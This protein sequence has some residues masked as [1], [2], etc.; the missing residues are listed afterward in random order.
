MDPLVDVWQQFACE[1]EEGA[2]QPMPSQ[3]LE[4]P[5]RSQD[6]ARANDMTPQWVCGL[7]ISALCLTVEYHALTRISSDTCASKEALYPVSAP[8]YVQHDKAG[9]VGRTPAA[10]LPN[11]T[12]LQRENI[13]M[14]ISSLSLLIGILQN[15]FRFQSSSCFLE[16]PCLYAALPSVLAVE[17]RRR[18]SRSS[19]LSHTLCRACSSIPPRRRAS[20]R[21]THRTRRSPNPHF[22]ISLLAS[23]QTAIHRVGRSGPREHDRRRSVRP[24]R[25]VVVVV[26]GRR[27][28]ARSE[29]ALARR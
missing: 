19:V 25:R 6:R 14:P 11:C 28:W 23:H 8:P 17:N 13:S 27:D 21:R 18:L 22:R 2:T 5:H 12:E 16:R 10:M 1:L 29:S 24:W 15:A 7:S 3:V 9:I 20:C 4:N 26:G